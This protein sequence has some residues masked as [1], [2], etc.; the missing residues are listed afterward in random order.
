[1][2]AVLGWCEIFGLPLL[3]V[4]TTVSVM[5][6]MLL[7][8]DDATLDAMADA[9]AR[10]TLSVAASRLTRLAAWDPTFLSVSPSLTSLGQRSPMRPSL[11]G[12]PRDAVDQETSNVSR[13][14]AILMRAY[15]DETSLH[16]IAVVDRDGVI[17]AGSD[18]T[19]P[20]AT[21]PAAVV[22][23]LPQDGAAWSIEEAGERFIGAPIHDAF[24]QVVAFAVIGVDTRLARS[25]HDA[26]EGRLPATRA[27]RGT[28]ASTVLATQ[29]TWRPGAPT[30]FMTSA[31]AL[32][33]SVF[34]YWQARRQPAQV[35]AWRA[36]WSLAHRHR[37]A[38]QHALCLL[39]SHDGQRGIAETQLESVPLSAP[40]SIAGPGGVL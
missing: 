40:R 33:I 22:S 10:V 27:M 31:M 6:A 4:F 34:A 17:R 13:V 23:R 25:R 5:S 11:A 29:R 24:G 3:L 14:L 36:G 35:R 30:F 39:K 2:R 12:V 38:L 32:A 16:W 37:R 8:H 1:M 26:K 28:P 9:R 20:G 21:L 19:A 7:P 18:A 15:Q